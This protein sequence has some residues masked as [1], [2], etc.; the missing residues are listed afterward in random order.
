MVVGLGTLVGGTGV[1]VAAKRWKTGTDRLLRALPDVPR[2]ES[3]VVR[4]E[5][6]DELPTPVQRYIRRALRDGQPYVHRAFIRQ[7]GDFRSKE[8]EDVSAGWQPFRATQT[9]IARSP[10]FVWDAKIHMAPFVDVWVR[11]AYVRSEASMLGA[12]V[13]TV[14]VVKEMDSEG[15]RSGALQRYL[16]EAVWFPTALLPSSSLKWSAIDDSHARATLIDGNTAVSLDFTFNPIGEIVAC[17]TPA[18]SRAEA[19]TAAGYVTRPWGGRYGLYQEHSGMQVP[20]ESVVYWVVNEREQPYYR[21]RNVS[22]QYD[23]GAEHRD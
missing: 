8:S 6:L 7:V 22:F 9:F 13:A 4:F 17:Y 10:G 3:E 12:V 20:S 11:D 14:P 19:G 2:S 5:A 1:A 15:L 18:R 21:G 23:F 16:A